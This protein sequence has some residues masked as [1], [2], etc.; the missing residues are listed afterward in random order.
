MKIGVH[1]I[2]MASPDDVT[3]LEKLIDA[4][5]VNPADIVAVIGKTE[6]NGGA[7]DF[8]RGYDD[9]PFVFFWQ[10]NWALN[11]T[12]SSAASPLSG[13]AAPKGAL[14]ARDDFYAHG[15]NIGAQRAKA[16]ARHLGDPCASPE[17]V[18]T[19]IMSAWLPTQS[20]RLSG[21][22]ASSTRQ[23]SITCK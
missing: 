9:S 6:G 12:T 20:V 10:K 18:G 21:K 2:A 8:T 15:R 7:N 23:M 11:S 19:T 13:P 1:K 16:C 3:A 17:E 5:E 14:A 4:G 22:Q